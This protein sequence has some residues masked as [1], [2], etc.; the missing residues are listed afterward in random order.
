MRDFATA[1]TA[2]EM[3]IKAFALEGSVSI[4]MDS[5]EESIVLNVL[6]SLT[7][8]V[9]TPGTTKGVASIRVDQGSAERARSGKII[10]YALDEEGDED[11]LVSTDDVVEAVVEAVAHVIAEQAREV[12]YS[13]FEAVDD[14]VDLED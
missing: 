5:E 8:R 11:T 9:T 7:N 13:I 3:A 2:V 4:Q 12:L 14:E 6:Q 1:V 10:A